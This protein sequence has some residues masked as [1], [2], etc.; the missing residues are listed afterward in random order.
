M[1]LPTFP[2]LPGQDI[3]V[4]RTVNQSG[5]AHKSLGGKKVA[6]TYQTYPTYT[7]EV[8]F[9]FLRAGSGYGITATE[10]QTLE[11]FIKALYG[12]QGMFLFSDPNDNAATA[13]LFGTGDGVTTTFQLVRTLGSFT[14]PVFF[15]NV[16][17]SV[18]VNGTP[19][20]AYTLSAT[21][22]VIFTTAPAG[23]APLAWTGTFY[24]G[25]RLVGETFD[26]EQFMT[27]LLRLGSLTFETE[28]L[29]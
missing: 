23:S 10:W 27:R 1:T 26:F 20:A 4:K 28:K 11:G 16:M 15:P 7:Y 8:S 14:E 6:T 22:Q 19:T 5:T 17:T 12:G 2:G 24:W 9:N 21:G 25:C 13:Q 18:T 3:V 29:V